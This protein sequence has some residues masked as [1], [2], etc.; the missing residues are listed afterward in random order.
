MFIVLTF[1]APNFGTTNLV[2]LKYAQGCELSNVTH[3]F[4]LPII[5]NCLP[6]DITLE[7]RFLK[8]IWNCFNNSNTIVQIIVNISMKNRK[9]V[10]GIIFRYLAFN[11]KLSQIIGMKT[12]NILNV[13]FLLMLRRRE[14]IVIIML[15][16]L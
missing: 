3:C 11:I 6:I 4:L 1:M 13:V 12:G 9:S 5:C 7:K 16:T 8:F 2:E 10:L 15:V 14:V